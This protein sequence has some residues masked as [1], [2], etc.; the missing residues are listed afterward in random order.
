MLALIA[1]SSLV[2]TVGKRHERKDGLWG[3]F[4]RWKDTRG[5]NERSCCNNL[6]GCSETFNMQGKT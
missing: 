5:V 1:K 3:Q 6:V 4:N 2:A